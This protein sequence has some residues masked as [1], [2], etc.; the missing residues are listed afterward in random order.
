MGIQQSPGVTVKETDLSQTVRTVGASVGAIVGVSKRGPVKKRVLITNIK[1]FIETFGT[2]NDK[3]SYMHYSALAFLS[4]AKQL[5]VTRVVASDARHAGIEILSASP[6]YQAISTGIAPT[7]PDVK[8]SYT[9]SAN[10]VGIIYAIGPG[11][12]ANSE[13]SIKVSEVDF[14]QTPNIFTL[15]VY[16]TVNGVKS[17]VETFKVSKTRAFDGLGRQTFWEDVINKRSK[18]IRVLNDDTDQSTPLAMSTDIAVT[19]GADGVSPSSSDV[20]GTNGWQLYANPDD[21]DINIMLCGGIGVASTQLV[22][23]TIAQSRRDCMA[24]LAVPSASQDGTSELTYRSTT[25]NLNSSFSAL[26]TPDVLIKDPY[27]NIEL[28]VPCDG[29]VG[30]IYALTEQVRESWYP[31]AGLNRGVINVLGLRINYTEGQR[32]TL[33]PK[34]VNVFR[35]IQG[36]GTALWGQRT[37]QSKE[38]AASRV[39]V[40]RLLIVVQK[41]VQAALQSVVFE[42]NND[43]T[44]LQVTQFIE[45]FMRRIKAKNGVYTYRVVCDES[46]NTDEV[47]DSE[48]LHVDIYLQP[49]RAAEFVQLQ[50]VIT[51]TGTN[52]NELIA[53]GGNF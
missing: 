46:N 21:V 29:H 12:Y 25:L 37:L 48:E 32:D 30:A 2:P 15:Q 17:I 47:I 28:Y 20:E 11:A 41:S 24:I 26:Y 9:F 14:T 10:G 34:Q 40:R 36:S 3:V 43:F 49:Q 16:Q 45:S 53:T 50:T 38:S 33:Y 27:N 22:M 52:F 13:I 4:V 35:T 1:E 8:P 39:N 42:L 6:G 5:Y 44:R 18:Y 7:S 31:P 19:L 23:D 51:R